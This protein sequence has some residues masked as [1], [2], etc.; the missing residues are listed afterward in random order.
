MISI[1]TLLTILAGSVSSA[2]A[3]A[4]LISPTSR[5]G[6]SV[7]NGI[8]YVG[9][10]DNKPFPPAGTD[11][12][13]GF[14]AG[15]IAATYTAGDTITVQWQNTIPHPSPPG[16]DIKIQ[17]DFAN[18]G[19][20]VSLATGVDDGLLTYDVTLDKT[21]STDHAVLRWSW[22]SNADGGYYVGC[23]DIAIK[24]AAVQQT[25]SMM[26]TTTM[27]AQSTAQ[28]SAAGSKT[29]SQSMM[30]M[31]SSS[32]AG[33]TSGT[34]VSATGATNNNKNAASTNGMVAPASF[35]VGAV[36]AMVLAMV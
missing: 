34:S 14:P 3:H 15:P 21:M 22:G 7:G 4:I 27:D 36:L 9:T 20:F 16:V 1:N 30:T 33:S 35:G 6:M 25:S 5:V 31:S 8:K 11:P 23:S 24:A 17:Y 2:M 10:P 28:S 29:T 19:P 13:Q 18:N 32:S 12:C 26:E